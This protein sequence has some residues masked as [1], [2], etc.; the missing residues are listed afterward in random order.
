MS[1]KK[2][3]TKS[4]LSYFGSD[5]EVAQRLAEMLDS[6]SHVTIPF[7]GGM[8]ILPF[9]KARAIVANDLNHFAIDFYKV[10]A[11]R[12]GYGD[13]D[14]L[15]NLCNATL[16]HPAELDNALNTLMADMSEANVVDRSWAYWAIC[17]IGRKGKGG[18]KD[19]AKSPSVRRKADGGNNATRVRSAAEDLPAWAKHFER[20]EWECVDFRDLLVKVADD[21]K[22]GVYCDPPWV[23][24][25]DAYLYPFTEKDHRE[26]CA[27]LSRFRHTKIVVR[28]GDDP[29]IRDLYQ[30]W[31]IH[32]ASTRTQA[33]TNIGELWIKNFA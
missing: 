23:G 8:S 14:E 20:C 6:C 16:S 1:D 31:I 15:I 28:Y 12:T 10:M 24:A 18:T 9:L 33:N 32:D 17:W 4:A 21:P 27:L 13:R 11:G 5:S 25:G 30:T 29:L 3:K 26:L 22:C 7:C 2:M 19:V